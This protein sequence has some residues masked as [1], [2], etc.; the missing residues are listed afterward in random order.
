MAKNNVIFDE[1]RKQFA[2]GE[3]SGGNGE[4]VEIDNVTITRNSEDK[5]Q[6]GKKAIINGAE[7]YLIDTSMPI[8]V[9]DNDD[10]TVILN[11]GIVSTS[12]LSD[13]ESNITIYNIEGLHLNKLIDGRGV[14][15]T[16][17]R[18]NCI[19]NNVD[20]ENNVTQN[21][22]FPKVFNKDDVYFPFSVNGTFADESGNISLPINNTNTNKSGKF[23]LQDTN[24]LKEIKVTET[25]T[26]ELRRNDTVLLLGVN[27]TMPLYAYQAN[28]N[29]VHKS[30]HQVQDTVHQIY[31]D[32]KLDGSENIKILFRCPYNNIKELNIW[33]DM[34]G[35]NCTYW[36]EN[37]H[38][39]YIP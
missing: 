24:S 6:L 11:N 17:Y 39:E 9:I 26:V 18:A 12:K 32:L 2:L 13:N 33:V 21:F 16:E 8:G 35:L 28:R 3:V 36:L 34:N 22:N 27:S 4:S 31:N 1:K 30:N 10:S 15:L 23:S 29:S 20:F 37:K 7:S 19:T 25:L 14:T 38:I 5:L